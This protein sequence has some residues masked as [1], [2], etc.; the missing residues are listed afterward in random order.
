MTPNQ[1]FGAAIAAVKEGKRISR[2][3]WNGKG[4]FVFRQVPAE[5]PPAVIPAMQ[6]LPPAVKAEF[7][8]RGGVIRYSDQLALVK[9][10]NAISGWT[11][12]PADVLAEDWCILDD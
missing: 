2:E 6:S 7:A 1:T 4:M 10:D 9:P 3:G 12:S 5:I 11:S 8:R